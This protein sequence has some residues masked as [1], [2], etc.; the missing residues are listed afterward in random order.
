MAYIVKRVYEA[1]PQSSHTL[2]EQGLT[3]CDSARLSRLCHN[4]V[5][6]V[7]VGNQRLKIHFLY[8]EEG[9]ARLCHIQVTTLL[10]EIKDGCVVGIATIKCQTHYN[11]YRAVSKTNLGGEI[12]VGI[13]MYCSDVR[14]QDVR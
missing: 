4:Q 2:F 12:V 9:P 13:C 11:K 1:M 7:L 3:I 6:Q 14:N 10:M 8:C 5:V